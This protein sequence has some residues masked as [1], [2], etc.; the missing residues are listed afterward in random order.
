MRYLEVIDGDR[1]L[2]GERT[3][4]SKLFG[5]PAFI[6]RDVLTQSRH[7]LRAMLRRDESRA[8]FREG[9]IRYRTGYI[10]KLFDQNRRESSLSVMG[11]VAGFLRSRFQRL[12]T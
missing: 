3:G 7:W 2:V 8:F 11:E 9:E 1:R 10:R 4:R 12:G 6:Y 5:V